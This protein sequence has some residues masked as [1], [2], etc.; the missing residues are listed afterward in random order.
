[1]DW[2]AVATA[3][4]TAAKRTGINALDHVPD[5][6]PSAA[7]YVGEMDI[8]FD[9]TF[10]RRGAANGDGTFRR[11]GTDQGTITCRVL[12]ARSDDKY[13]LQKMRKYMA[14]SGP[15]SIAE[16]FANDKTLGGTVD[17]SQV[18]RM[19]GNR[20]FDVGSQKFYGVE[21]D[22]FVIGAA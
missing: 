10:R 17:A 14:G 21:I 6:L 2:N 9:V 22:V 7:F 11:V 4:E 19:R 5:S 15:T 13:A 1:M 16:E 3:L 18:K 20:L 12:V 8:E